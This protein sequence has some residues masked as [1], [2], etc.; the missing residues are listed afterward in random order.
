M[1]SGHDAMSSADA[2]FW[3]NN[4]SLSRSRVLV[5]VE[6]IIVGAESN[7]WLA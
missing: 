1:T 4:A 2:M 3:Q 6:Y 5:R 7:S